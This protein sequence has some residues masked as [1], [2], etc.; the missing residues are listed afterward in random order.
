MNQLHP[1][2]ARTTSLLLI[3]LFLAANT[4]AEDKKIYQRTM[5]EYQVPDLILLNQEGQ[6]VHLKSYFDSDKLIVLDFIFGT[7]TTIC[8][9]LSVSFAHLQKKLG[10]DLDRVR[11]VS[12]SIDPD[13]D[14]PE[15]LK[16]H[17]QKYGAQP[18]WDA[19]T[20]KRENIIQVLKSFDAYVANKM[21]HFPLTI[22]RAPGEKQWVRLYGLLSASDLRKEYEQLMKK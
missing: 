14:T 17:L 3:L 16:E 18:G 8:P 12:I 21:D 11:L 13:N 5:E 9:V 10:E 7:C 22:L 15:V 2:L 6:E 1:R 4:W 19:L 20:G